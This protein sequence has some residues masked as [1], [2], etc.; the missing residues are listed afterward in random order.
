MG[1]SAGRRL[2]RYALTGLLVTGIHAAAAAAAVEFANVLPT[3]AN[4]AAFLVATAVSYL[5]NTYWS[6][7]AH[8][9][10]TSLI[11]FLIVAVLGGVTALAVSGLAHK[12]GFHYWIGIA[13]VV[14]AVPPL[15]FILHNAWTYKAGL[16]MS[17]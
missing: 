4:G 13:M 14:A 1:N 7:S 12:L 5:I 16:D 2:S 10:Q 6:F 15:T 11:R 8:P 9:H 17:K 3:V